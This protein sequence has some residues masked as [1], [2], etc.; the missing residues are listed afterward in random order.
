MADDI[1]KKCRLYLVRFPTCTPADAKFEHG[2]KGDYVIKCQNK[3]KKKHA[4]C[5]VCKQYE[6]KTAL[7]PLAKHL[8]VLKGG[9]EIDIDPELLVCPKCKKHMLE[10]SALVKKTAKKLKIGVRFLQ[11]TQPWIQEGRAPT[12]EEFTDWA[13]QQHKRACKEYEAAY[14]ITHYNGK[15]QHMLSR[16]K[17]CVSFFSHTGICETGY[18]VPERMPHLILAKF[19]KQARKAARKVKNTL[20]A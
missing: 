12:I 14:P 7:K 17:P 9:R 16:D 5:G 20:Y 10:R 18:F 1:C 15:C 4:K 3:A 6:L 8:W 11:S 19:D 2:E 13:R